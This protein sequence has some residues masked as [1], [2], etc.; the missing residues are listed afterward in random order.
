MDDETWIERRLVR[1]CPE[2]LADGMGW[3][4]RFFI[5][6][7]RGSYT[8]EHSYTGPG[9]HPT[10]ASAVQACFSLARQEVARL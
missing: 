3:S 9:T 1:A 10:R 2:E 4:E 8:D 6:E 7:S 5:E